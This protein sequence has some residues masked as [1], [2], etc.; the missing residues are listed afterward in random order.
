[1]IFYKIVWTEKAV[2]QLE[3]IHFFISKNSK[4]AADKIIYILLGQEK[5]I[6][7]FPEIGIIEKDT[8]NKHEYRYIIK[9]RYKILYRFIQKRKHHLYNSSI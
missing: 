5:L 8:H 6:A 9:G 2:R 7:S 1:M 3:S 4:I